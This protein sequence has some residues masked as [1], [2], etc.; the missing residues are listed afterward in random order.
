M[1]SPKLKLRNRIKIT[2]SPYA[3]S[4]NGKIGI[5]VGISTRSYNNDLFC[6]CF[7]DWHKGHN[8]NGYR[9]IAIKD[10]KSNSCWN[11]DIDYYKYIKLDEQLEFNFNEKT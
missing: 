10:N 8:G 7:E 1:T 4:L 6:I 11:I 2:S 3:P 5:V 9:K